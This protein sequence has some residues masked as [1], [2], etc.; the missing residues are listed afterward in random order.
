MDRGS[1]DG[2]LVHAR[3][4]WGGHTLRVASAYFPNDSSEQRRF[5]AA[6]LQPL[7]DSA[8]QSGEQPYRDEIHPNEVGQRIIAQVLEDWV[9]ALIRDQRTG[10]SSAPAPAATPPN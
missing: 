5:A 10:P 1:N 6:R 9:I 4:R 3:L 7:V 2:R 8:R